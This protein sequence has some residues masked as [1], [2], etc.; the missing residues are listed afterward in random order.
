[1]DVV[2][3]I[4]ADHRQIDRLFD[5]LERAA[6]AE[7]ERQEERLARQLVREL[8]VHAAVEEQVLYPALVRVGLEPERLDA[9]EDHHAVKVT[10]AELQAMRPAQARYAAKVRQVMKNVRRH[11]EEEEAT[12]LPQL[13]QSLDEETLQ[14][15]G[16]EFQ[17]LR[18]SAPTRPHPGA[19]DEPPAN[20]VANALVALLDRLKDAFEDASELV[21]NSAQHVFER[22][23]RSGRAAALR[24]RQGGEHFLGEAR[25]RGEWAVQ[26]ARLLGAE[27]AE[28]TAE[29]GAE[30]A[31]RIEA[32]VLP[33][34]HEVGR[35][36]RGVMA[37]ARRAPREAAGKARAKARD[38][39]PSKRRRTR[40]ART[41]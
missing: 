30:L 16:I 17:A 13:R 10:L 12:L 19:P 37:R 22:A 1:M 21:R 5:H 26:R 40:R 27:A 6:R 29:R 39:A 32:R 18:R 8:S 28:A 35:R 11:V 14:R 9:L 31:D 7:D 4:E 20:V 33:A 23:A 15:M 3:T 34:S 41:R 24:A 36:V 2:Q 25:A 38:G